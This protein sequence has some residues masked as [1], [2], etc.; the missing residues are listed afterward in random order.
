VGLA[1]GSSVGEGV[2]VGG[3][4]VLVGVGG[5][6]GVRVWV[7]VGGLVLKHWMLGD[8]VVVPANDAPLVE[9]TST[10]NELYKDWSS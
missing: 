8:L 3:F 5:V 6:V 9:L 2:F 7:A 1:V 4:G 10:R